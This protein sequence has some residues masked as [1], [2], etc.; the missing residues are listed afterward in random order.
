MD[1]H[2]ARLY[3]ISCV[4]AGFCLIVR[5]P[6]M[7]VHLRHQPIHS[8]HVGSNAMDPSAS[9]RRR[10]LVDGQDRMSQTPAQ[11]FTSCADEIPTSSTLICA[12]TK[13]GE[14][15]R[16]VAAGWELQDEV[17]GIRAH[18]MERARMGRL[19]LYNHT[20]NAHQTT[21]PP[22]NSST[23]HRRLGGHRSRTRMNYCT[24]SS[25]SCARAK[26]PVTN[27]AAAVETRSRGEDGCRRVRGVG[28]LLD[29]REEGRTR[30]WLGREVRCVYY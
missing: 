14:Q 24:T 26:E 27:A 7:D 1:A 13:L 9:S 17:E 25:S 30:N 15:A 10:S 6:R 23:L 3:S 11:S 5:P 2:R 16:T 19:D 21:C 18:A 4:L 8:L 29:E 22:L 28:L 20:P 12:E